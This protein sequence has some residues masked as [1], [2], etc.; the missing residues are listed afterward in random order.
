[1]TNRKGGPKTARGKAISSQ[2]AIKHGALSTKLNSK[3]DQLAYQNMLDALKDAYPQNHPLIH[4]Q[5]ERVAYL[6]VQL[7]RIQ[8]IIDGTF[9]QSREPHE[10]AEKIALLLEMTPSEG[11]DL[12]SKME[13]GLPDSIFRLS[14]ELDNIFK[15]LGLH[16]WQSFES[17]Q[18]FLD[19]APHLCRYL[20]YHAHREESTISNWLPKLNFTIS[21]SELEERIS[22]KIRRMYGL[23]E[24]IENLS[25]DLD[26]CTINKMVN[27]T[28]HGIFKQA[29]QQMID[30]Y[31]STMMQNYKTDIFDSLMKI[32][33]PSIGLKLDDLDKLYRYQTAIQRQLSTTI[34]ELLELNK[35][36]TSR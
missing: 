35:L 28:A 16:N 17:T 21:Q 6:K 13:K 36:T 24:K 33:D 25:A 5:L 27:E 29:C 34:G 20:A 1:M 10:R 18:E 19:Y 23:N 11:F 22:N 2:N 32:K 15:E 30:L 26:Q 8:R 31:K 4:L 9:A 7:D 12:L 3:Q 14:S